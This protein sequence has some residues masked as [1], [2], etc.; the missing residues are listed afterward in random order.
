MVDMLSVEKKLTGP[1]PPPALRIVVARFSFG[2]AGR[3]R[4]RVELQN[5]SR[6][7][8]CNFT[9][10]GRLGEEHYV[11]REAVCSG[12][13]MQA[14]A[15]LMDSGATI[16]TTESKDASSHSK[17]CSR[18]RYSNRTRFTTA[19]AVLFELLSYRP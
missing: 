8:P 17:H 14:A 1:L 10:E 9:C 4:R 6:C 5:P 2:E 15:N 19:A 13:E 16:T 18:C 11:T 12:N 7:L 3:P